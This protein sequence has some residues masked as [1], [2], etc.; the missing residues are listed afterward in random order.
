MLVIKFQMESL[1]PVSTMD[2][3]NAILAFDS[4]GSVGIVL[5]FSRFFEAEL[6][7]EAKC[8]SKKNLRN[9]DIGHGVLRLIEI[10][11]PEKLTDPKD[12][13]E[14]LATAVVI[15]VEAANVPRRNSNL[16]PNV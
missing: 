8:G 5:S 7:N 14:D 6:D 10:T 11:Q 13:L 4:F 9:E 1:T 16:K 15:Q 2:N 3:N 12:P